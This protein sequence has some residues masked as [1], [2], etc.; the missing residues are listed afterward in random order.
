MDRSSP[1]QVEGLTAGV[2]AIT[3]GMFHTCALVDATARCWGY[4]EY[5]ELGN[6][7]NANSLV[8]VLV[9]F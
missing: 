7:S 5:G 9:E 3:A 2:T 1:T 4:N 8:P 6:G